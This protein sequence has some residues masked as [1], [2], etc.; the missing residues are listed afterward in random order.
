LFDRLFG[1]LDIVPDS[2][3][4]RYGRLCFLVTSN[5]RWLWFF[6]VPFILDIFFGHRFFCDASRI[7]SP[8]ESTYA[9]ALERKPGRQFSI[10]PIKQKRQPQLPF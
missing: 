4:L 5:Q 6:E 3:V 10:M 8:A 1:L 9:N 2:R 7:G